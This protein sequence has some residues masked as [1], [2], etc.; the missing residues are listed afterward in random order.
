MKRIVFAVI[1]ATMLTV[2]MVAVAS[3]QWPTTC[4]EL[5]DIVEAHLG[6]HGNVGIYQ[7]TF[8]DQA[9]Q[10]C[11]NDHRDDV[12][13]VFAWAIST[14]TPAPVP[15]PQSQ[16]VQSGTGTHSTGLFNLD[17]G[18]YRATVTLSGNQTSFGTAG[19]FS[20]K[21][22]SVAGVYVRSGLLVNELTQEGRWEKNF[23]IQKAGDHYL[24]V[25]ASGNGQWHV[26]IVKI[27]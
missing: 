17:V 18:T 23:Q 24:D 8:G 2:G 26:E 14:D 1:A 27:G 15:A 13:S 3:A 25:K 11:Q 21:V 19:H 7:N 6:N 16:V 9:E 20:A 12:R 5:N 10:A 22:E 4:V